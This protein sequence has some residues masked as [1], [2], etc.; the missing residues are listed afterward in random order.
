V[1]WDVAIGLDRARPDLDT[2][3]GLP[4]FQQ[5]RRPPAAVKDLSSIPLTQARRGTRLV[6]EHGLGEWTERDQLDPR[7]RAQATAAPP[8]CRAGP[9]AQRL[10]DLGVVDDD[11][12]S[13]ASAEKVISAK[14]IPPRS[15]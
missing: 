2:L 1:A 4:R 15:R 8:A 14:R 7:F 5:N 13:P 12:L 3:R 9:A 11:E 6:L 10:G